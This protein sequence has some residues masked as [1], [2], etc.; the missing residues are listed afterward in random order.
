MGQDVTQVVFAAGAVRRQIDGRAQQAEQAGGGQVR[1]GVDRQGY[2]VGRG[3]ER[4]PGAPQGAAKARVAGDEPHPHCRRWDGPQGKE[5]G[6]HAGRRRSLLHGLGRD[7]FALW[8]CFRRWSGGLGRWILRGGSRRGALRQN[9]VL[10]RGGL[11]QCFRCGGDG[12]VQLF[13]RRRRTLHGVH[14]AQGA[15]PADGQQQPHQ[16]QR[17]QGILHPGMNAAAQHGT[18]ADQGENQNR[19]GDQHFRN[20]Y[21]HGASSSAFCRIS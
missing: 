13:H 19:R 9:A 1:R 14:H 16:H 17:P 15:A 11:G 3:V 18:Q 4:L 12:L 8:R 5:H 6:L 20:R 7:S 10:G 2:P 21:D